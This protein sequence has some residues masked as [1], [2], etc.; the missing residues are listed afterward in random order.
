[1]FYCFTD[2]QD[3]TQLTYKTL[4]CLSS[5]L[6]E[7]MVT[8]SNEEHTQVLCHS[9]IQQLLRLLCYPRQIKLYSP[10]QS[11]PCLRLQN[12]ARSAETT[13]FCCTG[14]SGAGG[15]QLG[16]SGWGNVLTANF[17]VWGF[18]N[19]IPQ[20]SWIHTEVFDQR[21]LNIQSQ[22]SAA[23]WTRE[24][25]VSAMSSVN[26]MG[27]KAPMCYGR[28]CTLPWV[29]REDIE[30]EGLSMGSLQ[31]HKKTAQNLW[32]SIIWSTK[33]IQQRVKR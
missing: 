11:K 31:H 17:I 16:S 19:K 29:T 9:I 20:F 12:Q 6:R 8:Q 21:R 27:P 33:P 1:M 2:W 10:H 25:I 7:G 24:K 23:F 5:R 18:L 14:K 26:P 13:D 15:M 22:E 32:I 30:A 4:Y 28:A 3:Q